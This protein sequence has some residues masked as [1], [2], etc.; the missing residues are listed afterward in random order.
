EGLL[1]AAHAVNARRA[2]V[3]LKA[4]FTVEIAGLRAALAEMKPELEVEIV[5]GPEEYL[6]GEEK[7]LLNVIEGIGPLPREAHSP[8]YE[9]GLFATPNSPNPT[10]VN[11]AETLAHVPSILRLGAASFRKLG[12]E[13]T[14]GTVLYTLS[15][16]L[17]RPGV[18]EAEPGRTVRQLLEELG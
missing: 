13:D 1:I 11:N 4:S 12:S 5:E 16:D 9:V 18:Y 10:L 2:F 7:A 3:A 17:L 8:P 6:Y 15:G 14:P